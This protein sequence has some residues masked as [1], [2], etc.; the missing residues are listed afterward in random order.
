MKLTYSHSL[1]LSFLFDK[2]KRNDYK[3]IKW[4]SIICILPHWTQ[5]SHRIL[6]F[7]LVF[8][9]T[10]GCCEA[11]GVD[12]SN[13]SGDPQ[14]KR[15]SESKAEVTL[16]KVTAQPEGV[17]SLTVYLAD[18]GTQ[19]LSLIPRPS[20]STNT[21]SSHFPFSRSW[22]LHVRSALWRR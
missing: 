19:G 14:I 12:V 7:G 5:V 13:M 9:S 6:C 1:W 16:P 4:L 3:R 22:F 8:P 15:L 20:Q 11:R 10:Q 2:V 18:L 17:E 21:P